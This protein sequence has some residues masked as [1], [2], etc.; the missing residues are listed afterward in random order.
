MSEFHG[1]SD[2][3]GTVHGEGV[4][5]HIEPYE[6]ELVTRMT[7]E[8]TRHKAVRAHLGGPD[9]QIAAFELLDKDAG[10]SRDLKPSS[11]TR[12]TAGV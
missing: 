2:S 3:E 12:M 9:L 5:I 10:S 4:R 1:A 6:P 8:L 7:A 11:M